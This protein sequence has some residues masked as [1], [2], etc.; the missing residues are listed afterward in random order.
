MPPDSPPA[1][2]CRT[3][4]YLKQGCCERKLWHECEAAEV[5]A[6]GEVQVRDR[7]QHWP[8]PR[9]RSATGASP[10]ADAV[11][12]WIRFVFAGPEMLPAETRNGRPRL[13]RLA[14]GCG[15]CRGMCPL[16]PRGNLCRRSSTAESRL[17]L[18]NLESLP[19]SQGEFTA[20]RRGAF[21]E[22]NPDSSC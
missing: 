14:F 1:G 20:F 17:Q 8:A 5:R 18:L 6:A 21:P 12:A 3:W 22:G 15:A 10:H 16:L 9:P 7:H 2:A 19:A 11:Q 4:S 13:S